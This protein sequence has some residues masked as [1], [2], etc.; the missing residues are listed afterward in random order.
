M[1]QAHAA[2]HS[3]VVAFWVGAAIF[4][5]AA[6]VVAAVLPSGVPNLAANEEM[7]NIPTHV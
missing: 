4:V 1:V 2:L 3:Y 6:L 5:G 7:D